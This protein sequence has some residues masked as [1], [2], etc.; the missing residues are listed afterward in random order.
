MGGDRC[1]RLVVRFLSERDGVGGRERLR[2]QRCH[3]D[4]SAVHSLGVH[5]A[6]PV[7]TEVE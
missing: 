6:Q 4:D 5:V 1:R 7:L 3:G 2:S